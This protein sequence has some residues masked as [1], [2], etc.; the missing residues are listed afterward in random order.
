MTNR[1]DKLKNWTEGH[2]GTEDAMHG[3]GDAEGGKVQDQVVRRGVVILTDCTY[4]G[5]Q[6]KGIIPWPEI[7]DYYLAPRDPQ[8]EQR[9]H[10]NGIQLTRQGVLQRLPCNGCHK[11]FRQIVDW[12][13]VSRYIDIA[14]RSG[15]LPPQIIQAARR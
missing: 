2:Q 10:Q 12:G 6:W 9:L 3:L 4:C 1:T 5:R 14:V 8:R 7:A 11:S 13:E 15:S